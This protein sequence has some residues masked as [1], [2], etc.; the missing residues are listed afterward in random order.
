MEVIENRCLT[1][2]KVM[3]D[4]FTIMILTLNKINSF[5]VWKSERTNKNDAGEEY[6]QTC[7]LLSSKRAA[8][9]TNLNSV[10]LR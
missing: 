9:A 8:S 4:G 10:T 7:L 1:L 2:L 5:G 6:K 3:K